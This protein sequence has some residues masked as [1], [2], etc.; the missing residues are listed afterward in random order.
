MVLE[1]KNVE[2]MSDMSFAWA[3][4]GHETVYEKVNLDK[5]LLNK[6]KQ[7]FESL[8]TNKSADDIDE[9]TPD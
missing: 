3:R 8:L 7:L 9:P 2:G 1:A 6:I 5:D 4:F